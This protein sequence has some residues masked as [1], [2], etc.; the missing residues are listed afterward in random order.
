MLLK[1]ELAVVD[2]DPSH[3]MAAWYAAKHG[4]VAVD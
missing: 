2:K 1:S 3:F 4:F